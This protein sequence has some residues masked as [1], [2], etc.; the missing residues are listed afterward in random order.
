MSER[1]WTFE[2]GNGLDMLRRMDPQSADHVITDPPYSAEVHAANVATN[3]KG[4]EG[5]VNEIDFD[6]MSNRERRAAARLFAKVVKRWVIIF[7]DAESVGLWRT[8]LVDA[9]LKWIRTGWWG[10]TNAAPQKTGDRPASPGESICIAHA[11]SRCIWNGGGRK[12]QWDYATETRGRMHP[13]QKPEGLMRHLLLDFTQPGDLVVDP[14]AGYGTTGHAA[15]RCGRRFRGAEIRPDYAEGAIARLVEAEKDQQVDLYTRQQRVRDGA[16]N[17]EIE[18]LEI[19][20]L[21]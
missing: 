20:G 17:L 5:G 19:E 15:V 14:Y 13:T 12:A 6:F 11:Q 21:Q 10:K 2:K 1:L 7:T 16:K 3:R 4:A 8:A 18:G 9:G